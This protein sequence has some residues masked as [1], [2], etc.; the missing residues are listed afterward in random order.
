[1]AYIEP[2]TTVKFLSGVPFDPDY[3]NTMYFANAAAQETYMNSKAFMTINKN[4]YQR[5]SRG[6][7]K[8]GYIVDTSNGG[9]MIRLLY[10]ANYMMFKNTNFEN[11]WFYAFVTNVEYVN[12]NTVEVSYTLDIVQSWLFAFRFNQCLIEREH[13]ATDVIGEHTL[14]ENLEHGPYREDIP[15]FSIGNQ[16][17]N[18]GIFQYTPA[19]CL[20]TTFDSQGAY[21]PGDILGGRNDM[22]DTYSGLHFNYW[23]LT[24][25]NVALINQTLQAITNSAKEYGVVALFMCP[26][27]FASAAI[28]GGHVSP[29]YLDF[30]ININLDGY[31]P[32]NKKLFVYPYNFLYVD[33]NQGNAAEYKW[34]EF[35][36]ASNARLSIWGNI[37]TNPGLVCSPFSY[38]GVAGDNEEEKI[39]LTGFPMC[40][41]SNDAFKAWVA[42]NAATLAGSVFSAAASWATMLANPIAGGISEIGR[43]PQLASYQPIQSFGRGFASNWDASP[44]QT[45][46]TIGGT[47]AILGQVF[48]H[49]RQPPHSHGDSNGNLQFQN[50]YLTFSFRRKFIKAEYAKI[51]DNF[52]DMYGYATHRVGTPNLNARP[53]YSYVKTVGASIDG[54]LPA[55]DCEALQRIFNKGIRFW[56]TSATFGSFDPNVNDNRPT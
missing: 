24:T 27:E 13:T 12:N 26:A 23:E 42:Q 49:K 31:V 17:Y 5:K 4:S 2:N 51:I 48:D 3:E 15:T 30:S 35:S 14:P 47:M 40:A 18:S 11:K 1:M 29:K 22:G 7:M 33:N 38:K 52:F 41:W 34:E 55:T 56:K 25:A 6:V 16:T 39:S 46:G 28:T 9:S 53:C 45:A 36:S 50:G 10:N 21:S 20:V 37:S 19:V 43:I 44:I 32:R 8:V 54:E